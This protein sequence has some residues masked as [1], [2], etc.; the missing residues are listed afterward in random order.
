MFKHKPDG[1]TLAKFV[2]ENSPHYADGRSCR[3]SSGE[4]ILKTLKV[5]HSEQIELDQPNRELSL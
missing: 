2:L 5:V 4:E 1:F 3:N